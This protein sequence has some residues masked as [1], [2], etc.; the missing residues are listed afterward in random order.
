MLII[1]IFCPVLYE[2]LMSIL[3]NISIYS[4]LYIL[5]KGK[6][7]ICLFLL[8]QTEQTTIATALPQAQG[9]PATLRLSLGQS[10]FFR[11]IYIEGQGWDLNMTAG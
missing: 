7:L 10:S 6:T 9:L 11:E 8:W 1:L 5:V 2:P 3:L 4:G